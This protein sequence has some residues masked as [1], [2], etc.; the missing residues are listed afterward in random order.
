[1]SEIV[2]AAVKALGERLGDGGA[3]TGLGGAVRFVIDGEG[4]LRIDPDGVVAD[5]GEDPVDCTL[6]ADAD[7]FRA[8]L[9]GELDP[10]AAFMSGRLAI[11]GD[12]GLAMKLGSLLG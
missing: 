5:G 11:D 8:L 10:T 12:M 6:T 2:D 1:M 7:T 9:D 4:A 3:G